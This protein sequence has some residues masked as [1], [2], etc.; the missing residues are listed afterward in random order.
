MT[1]ASGLHEISLAGI[2]RVFA[3]NVRALRDVS[4]QIP[5]G[6]LTTIVGPSGCGKTTLLRIMGGLD[7]ATDGTVEFSTGP[8]GPS[9]AQVSFGFQEARLLP[10]RTV[11]RNI[12]LPL[13]L[14]SVPNPE[15]TER[16]IHIAVQVGLV[17]ALD[18]LPAQLS[19]G[20]RMRAAIARSL[21]TEPNVLLLDEPF[22][23]LDEITRLTLDDLLLSLWQ[24]LK[25]TVVLVTHSISEAVYLG[26]Q[27][28]V[29]SPAP[30][31]IAKVMRPPFEK[32]VPAIRTTQEFALA[33]AE[34]YRELERGV[35]H[36]MKEKSA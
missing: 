27:V 4:L 36:A 24:Q 17:D 13:E 15:R 26:Q 19:G 18:R 22:G 23:S 32:R 21:V 31:R 5:A 28:V 34:V 11:T 16:A 29:M 20:M 10:W 9:A 12:A 3:G 33:T 25:M 35:E 6:S 7:K 8:E 1:A 2:G 14:C 30:G